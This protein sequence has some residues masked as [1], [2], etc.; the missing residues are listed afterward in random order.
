VELLLSCYNGGMRT[1]PREVLRQKRS[2]PVE[3]TRRPLD[4][5]NE[6]D[7]VLIAY[8]LGMLGDATYNKQHRTWRITQANKEWLQTL[9]DML[10]RLGYR[11]W[12][13]REGK[14]RKVYALETTAKSLTKEV[15]PRNLGTIEERTAY[16]RGYFDAEGGVP[17]QITHRMYIQFSQKNK[18][19][20][21]KLSEVLGENG[22]R[23]GKIHCP[24][25]K[26]DPDYWRFFIACQSHQDFIQK[27]GS[28]HPRK[29]QILQSRVKI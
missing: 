7:A 11:S 26:V 8:L 22:I 17:R 16:V 27:I 4:W 9:K 25:S 18:D 1:I 3:T 6:S 29:N 15:D 24:S 21:N 14:Q 12:M 28:W 10:L 13:Y 5:T 20:L 19:E 23:C 2:D